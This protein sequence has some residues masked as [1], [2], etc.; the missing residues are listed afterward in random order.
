MLL[1]Y[2]SMPLIRQIIRI[3]DLIMDDL[4]IFRLKHPDYFAQ[5]PNHRWEAGKLGLDLDNVFTALPKQF[6]LMAIP[7]LNRESFRLE[8]QYASSIAN[9]RDEFY[10]LLRSRMEARRKEQVKIMMHALSHLA[11]DLEQI[12]L[13]DQ[14]DMHWEHAMH[15]ARSKSF[16]TIMQFFAGFLRNKDPYADI[17]TLAAG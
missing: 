14:G 11:S 4:G 9:N 1:L 13:P 17:A 8:T 5:Y 15:I 3:K 10:E 7:I 6:N 16:N 2:Q 12:D